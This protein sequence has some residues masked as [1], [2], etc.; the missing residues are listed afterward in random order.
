VLATL[1]APALYQMIATNHLVDALMAG[2]LQP[3]AQAILAGAN[4]EW[5]GILS[6]PMFAQAA[7]AFVQDIPLELL[8]LVI[9]QGIAPMVLTG[10]LLSAHMSIFWLSQDSNVTPPV[11]I[12]AYA[13]A[14]IADTKPLPTGLMAWKV[15]KGLYIMPFLFA[16][17]PLLSGDWLAALQVFAFAVVGIY[18]LAAALEGF[19]ER[20][21]VPLTQV[22]VGLAGVLLLWPGDLQVN[23]VGLGLFAALFLLNRRNR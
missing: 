5:A 4:A 2:T 3:A 22:L 9:E 23:F 8:P 6:E 19:M 15:A 13:A 11:C 14:A 20:R 16:Y 18:A 7:Q 1:T 10:I 12:V 17:T 21:L